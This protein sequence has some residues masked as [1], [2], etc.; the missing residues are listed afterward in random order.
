[1]CSM[2]YLQIRLQRDQ[3]A[4]LE[5]LDSQILAIYALIQVGRSE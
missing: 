1:L 4:K 5:S 2:L 3:N